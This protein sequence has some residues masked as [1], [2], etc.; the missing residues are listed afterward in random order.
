MARRAGPSSGGDTE[1]PIR[2]RVRP[3]S[4]GPA[5]EGVGDVELLGGVFVT[6]L[7]LV[8]G[9]FLNVVIHRVPLGQ[10]VVSPPSACPG[11]GRAIRPVENIPVASWVL[12]RGRCRGCEEPISA[13]YPAVEALTGALFAILYAKVGPEPVLVPI[14]LTAA[15]GVAL[16]AIDLEH[17]RLP[18]PITIPLNVAVAV[19][20]IGVGIVDGFDPLGVALASAAVWGGLFFVL[21][22]GTAGRGMG[23][24]DVV[25][26]PGLG[27]L[28]GWLGWGPSVVGLFGSFAIGAVVGVGL[29]MFAGLGRKAKVPFGPFMLAGALLGI[30][31]G[32]PVWD[33]YL[34]TLGR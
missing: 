12:L 26:A 3:G 31:V 14:L 33:A 4:T 32:D 23:F 34:D 25:L 28:L 27:L 21:W 16:A 6:L 30:L 22:F 2:L 15:A 10:S 18:F 19:S 29:R 13:R 20:L 17:H 11:C 24:G 8:I 7:G 5:V 1:D 9:S